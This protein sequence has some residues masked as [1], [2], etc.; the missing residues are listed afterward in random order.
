MDILV[1]LAGTAV[2]LLILYII[3][4]VFSLPLKVLI[5]LVFNAIG[6]AVLLLIFNLLGGVFGLNIDIN[7]ISALIAGIL[8]IPGVLLLLLLQ[9]L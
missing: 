3:I 6:G 1:L 7:F 9:F 8:G 5:K 2:G 4:K